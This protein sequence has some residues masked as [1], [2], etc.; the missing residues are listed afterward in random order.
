LVSGGIYL[1]NLS[2]GQTLTIRFRAT[3]SGNYLNNLIPQPAN[4]RAYVSAN[5]TGDD[6]DNVYVHVSSTIQPIIYQSDKISVQKLGK[7]IT[8]GEVAEKAS[9]AASPNDTLEFI[10]KIR[11][12]YSSTL[13]NVTVVDALPY[14]LSYIYKTT[15]V[16]GILTSDNITGS[17][18]NVG[19]LSPNQEIVIRLNA[20]VNSEG[21]FSNDT[22]SIVNTTRV[23]ADNTSTVTAQL[24][25]SITKGKVAGVSISKVAGV[26]T[27]T[28]GSLTI[29]LLLSALI[30][31]GYMNYTKTGLFKKREALAVIKEHRLNKNK[32]N[33]VN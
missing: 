3:A 23:F 2:P 12:L 30:T 25:I 13:Y 11:S 19:S 33:F 8:Q 14:G 21:Y 26:A 9:L 31:F 6:S 32:F 24:P 4:S 10:I 22:T 20:L 18:L 5:N 29:S 16:N 7:N 27:G 28:A 1:G 15:S 17:G